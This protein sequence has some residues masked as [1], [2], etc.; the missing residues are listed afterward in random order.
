MKSIDD[1]PSF[2]PSHSNTNAIDCATVWNDGIFESAAAD[3]QLFES[4]LASGGDERIAIDPATGR[5]RYG[6]PQGKAC[7]EVWFSSSTASAISPRGYEAALEALRSL[8]GAHQKWPVS[9]WFD[10]IRDRL[11]ALFGIPQTEVILSSSGTELELI[12][13]VLSRNIL[14]RPLTNIVIAPAETGR[15]VSLAAAGRYFLGS[16]PFAAEVECG[17]LLDGL[18]ASECKVEIVEIRDQHGVPRSADSIDDA[19]VRSVEAIIA[20]GGDV[21]VHLLD[22]SKTNRT[23]LRR[24]AASVLMARYP[25]RLVVVVDACQLRCSREQIQA[26]LN[27]G[28]MVMMTG[29]KFAGAPPFAGALLL[30]PWIVARLQSARLPQGLFAYT[31]AN[32]WSLGL[33]GRLEGCFVAPANVGMGLRWEA[34][35]GELESLFALDIALRRRVTA[36]F[37]EIVCEHISSSSSLDLIDRDH[38]DGD[39]R[40]RTIF[41][42]VTCDGNGMPLAADVMQRALRTPFQA[43]IADVPGRVFHVGQPVAVGNRSAV[44]VCLSAPA[45]T[46]VG[47]RM[48]AGQGFDAAFA[49]LAADV[50]D[51]F[52]KWSYVRDRLDLAQDNAT[53]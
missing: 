26:D 33:R 14:H 7:D 41:P 2:P 18:E 37:S 36:R 12:A 5:N 28:F 16:T 27:A 25:G 34:A 10:R 9:R 24:R 20:S 31:A 22:C 47:E 43:G 40:R 23:G 21:L 8:T 1:I 19:V 6:A 45:I 15:G 38:E 42:I 29:S 44:R 17:G 48:R 13:L 32:D 39:I 46:D 50:A 35:L 52:G 4:I 3:G 53:R 49:P 30:P 11:A 51:L